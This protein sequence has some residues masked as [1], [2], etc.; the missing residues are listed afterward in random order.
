[1]RVYSL[2]VLIEAMRVPIDCVSANRG[3]LAVC[4]SDNGMVSLFSISGRHFNRYR[5][6]SVRYVSSYANSHVL[7]NYDI[8]FQYLPIFPFL[9]LR[10]NSWT[11]SRQKSS[12]FS[13]LLFTITSTALPWDFHF[14]KL[15]Q[16]LTV[17]I[18]QSLYTVKEKGAKP[19]INP[20]RDLKPENS[21][22]HAQ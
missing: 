3:Q 2:N 14:F 19:D 1:V 21:Q 20:Y 9:F 13:A 17:F 7:K 11:F 8:I 16:P 6:R 5:H 18:V 10:T 22:D 4:S 15:T 12:E